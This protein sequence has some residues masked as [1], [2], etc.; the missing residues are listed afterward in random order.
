MNLPASRIKRSAM[1]A[2][3]SVSLTLMGCASDPREG[4]SFAASHDRT[5]RSVAVPIF[6]NTTFA[7]G[8]ETELTE[9]IIKEI[10]STTPWRVAP[11]GA[12]QSVLTGTISASTLDAF[13][14]NR[15]TG[16]AQELNVQLTVN[17]AWKDA[18][19]GKVLQARN[20][21]TATDSFIPSRPVGERIEVGE[22]GA[23][24][25]MARDIVA[26]MRSEW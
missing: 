12:A 8:I 6:Q 23:I 4:Y 3:A 1:V 19:T 5:L 13:S 25:R 17:F 15:D 2:A 16:Y 10:Q 26:V 21:F 24:Q 11:Q 18:R 20:N 14:T 22:R 9:A 7:R